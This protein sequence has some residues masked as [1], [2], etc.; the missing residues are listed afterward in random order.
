MDKKDALRILFQC[1][2]L[3]Q[4]NLAGRNILLICA[5]NS[6]NKIDAIEALFEATNFLHLTG[7]KFDDEARMSPN[8]FYT[9]CLQ[10]R[11]SPD[12]F[13][14][15]DDG[16]TELKLSVLPHIFASSN[17]SANMIGDYYDRRPTLITE[18]LAG[19]IRGCIGFVYDQKIGCYTPNTILNI[20]MR[21]SIINRQRVIATYCKMK[22]D[23]QYSELV[24]KARKVDWANVKYPTKY[25][26][27]Q[28]QE[29]QE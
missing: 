2:Q 1:A 9:L 19:D 5:N 20:D 26:Y 23:K 21:D 13:R 10:K 25:S 27:I 17:L 18:K 7:V 22:K 28:L 16:T 11:L 29:Q 14:L 8:T 6:L 24:Y 3:Y 15:A 12:R 4:N